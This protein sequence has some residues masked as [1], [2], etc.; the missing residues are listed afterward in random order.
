MRDALTRLLTR[1]ALK[2]LVER[3]I[4][5]CSAQH[6]EFAVVVIDLDHFKSINDA[7]GHQRGDHVLA[8]FARRASEFSRTGDTL[9][10]YGGDEFVAILSDC[11]CAQA[12]SFAWRL[13]DR[14]R[15]TPFAGEPPLTLTLSAGVAAYPADGRSFDE[16]F[17]AADRRHYHAKHR[18]R[19]QVI[20][21]GEPEY[22]ASQGEAPSRLIERDQALL[23]MQQFLQAQYAHTRSLLRM[24]GPQGAGHTRLLAEMRQAAAMRAIGVLSL[25]GTTALRVRVAGALIEALHTTPIPA[26][27]IYDPIRLAAELQR[28]LDQEGLDGLLLTIDDPA[29]LDEATLDILQDLIDRPQLERLAIVVADAEPS[30]LQLRGL[31][32]EEQLSL[33]ALTSPGLRTWLRHSLRWEPPSDVIEWLH[34]ESGG[35]PGPFWRGLQRLLATKALVRDHGG[36]RLSAPYGQFPL[37]EWSHAH[38]GLPPNNLPGGLSQYVGR[39]ADLRRL[40]QQLGQ[41]RA[42]AIVGPGGLGKT[43]L[44]LQAGMEQLA[45]FP[46][47]VFFVDLAE[48]PSEAWALA[49][50]AQAAGIAITGTDPMAALL[51]VLRDR[52]TLLILDNVEG[53]A[54][55][56]AYVAML[57]EHTPALTILLTSRERPALAG[58]ALMELSGLELPASTQPGA[59]LE[60]A[61][62]QLFLQRAR[63]VQPAFDPDERERAAIAQICRLLDGMPLGIELAAAWV[64]GASCQDILRLIST[65]LRGLEGGPSQPD[66]RHRRIFAV[67]DTFWQ[68]MAPAECAMLRTLGL[69]RSGFE[70]EAARDVGGVSPFFL[71]SL[72]TSGYLR[73]TPAGRYEMHELLRQYALRELHAAPRARR[74]AEER[75]ARYYGGRVQQSAAALLAGGETLAAFRAE[76]DNILAAWEWAIRRMHLELLHTIGPGLARYWELSGMPHVGEPFLWRAITRL[77]PHL[78]QLAQPDVALLSHLLCRVAWYR[79]LRQSVV[80]DDLLAE[81]SRYAQESESDDAVVE[82]I[83]IASWQ[84]SLTEPGQARERLEYALTLPSSTTLANECLRQLGTIHHQT[85]HLGRAAETLERALQQFVACGDR[86]GEMRTICNLVDLDIERLAYAAADKRV[87]RLLAQARAI[88]S[89]EMECVALTQ[90]S[91]SALWRAALPR[92]ESFLQRARL[93]TQAHGDHGLEMI[94]LELECI[95]ADL[96]GAPHG[97][98]LWSAAVEQFQQHGLHSG[99]ATAAALLGHAL[100]KQGDLDGAQQAYERAAAAQLANGGSLASEAHAGLAAALHARGECTAAMQLVEALLGALHHDATAH[101]REPFALFDLIGPLLHANGD[102]RLPDLRQEAYALFSRRLKAIEDAGERSHYEAL[103]LARWRILQE[104]EIAAG[105]Y[106]TQ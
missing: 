74:A 57:L 86:L 104:A 68:R 71:S 70:A 106:T 9:I 23:R 79:L 8:E 73:R 43:R 39:A 45:R 52:T 11:S 31:A 29:Q 15:T 105:C 72:V 30:S 37:R 96:G 93:I 3:A 58:C 94:C 5:H 83:L 99:I 67:I 51:A 16:L 4:A 62:A 90:L 56:D 1:A 76:L 41:R 82:S 59:T 26:A 36:W 25:Q 85:H 87:H 2:P 40:Q 44:A 20:G 10:R 32:R 22:G 78:G 92:A 21:D 46:D 65:N 13:L 80:S 55:L 12:V 81:A 19:A 98:A 18:G 49:R 53:L 14:M 42:V 6:S 66:G 95:L 69:F 17:A 35:L 63:R 77:R 28:W 33:P 89:V 7:F 100:R 103:M 91:L 24:R 84:Y 102:P 34:S 61:S 50:I 47:G 101:M 48:A 38:L 88:G 60:S 54:G 97:E 75:H 64:T 27:A